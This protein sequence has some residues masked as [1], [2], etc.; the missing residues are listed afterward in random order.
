MQVNRSISTLKLRKEQY[1][2]SKSDLRSCFSILKRLLKTKIAKLRLK[3][4][5][6]R[7]QIPQLSQSKINQR[8]TIQL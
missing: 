5:F 7:P 8:I 4:Q 1:Q 6:K 3:Y 2:L